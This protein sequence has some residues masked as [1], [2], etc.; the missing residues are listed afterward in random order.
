[1]WSK[2]WRLNPMTSGM[3]LNLPAYI[4]ME[5]NSELHEWEHSLYDPIT[6]PLHWAQI[7]IICEFGIKDLYWTINSFRSGITI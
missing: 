2:L 7:R 5:L 1:M 3:Q 4:L 6:L